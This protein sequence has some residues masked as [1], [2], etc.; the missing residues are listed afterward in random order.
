[1]LL[2][3]LLV[4]N[5]LEALVLDGAGSGL[6]AAYSM[7]SHACGSMAMFAGSGTRSFGTIF[8]WITSSKRN[9]GSF[10]DRVL[11]ELEECPRSDPA[12]QHRG[13][14]LPMANMHVRVLQTLVPAWLWR[15][16]EEEGGLGIPRDGAM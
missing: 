4:S 7:M 16:V 2:L 9:G 3:V 10:F 13:N 6:R 11:E 1:M 14:V 15:R 12:E 5:A 8:R